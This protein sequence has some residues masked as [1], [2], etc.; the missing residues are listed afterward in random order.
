MTKKANSE[1]RTIYTPQGALTY[2]LFRKAVKNVN[3][4]IDRE[5]RVK[6]SANP[7]V[8]MSFI[9]G[10]VREKERFIREGIENVRK[11]E[12]ER[13]G[14]ESGWESGRQML[15]LGSP[16]I[17]T[18]QEGKKEGIVLKAPYLYLQ[19]KPG[20]E[21]GRREAIW[22]AWQKK[23]AGK[24][25]EERLRRMERMVAS[26]GIVCREMSIRRMT[27]RWGSCQPAKG[28]ITLNT[29]LV[30][31]PVEAIDYVVLHELAHMKYPHHQ[32]SFYDFI[33]RFMPD[34]KER[35]ELLK[36]II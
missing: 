24:I 33:D 26:Y 2:E 30:E 11:R 21:E 13:G 25:L 4:R 6:V 18:V 10:F 27:S 12:A 15:V 16:F 23:L 35:R 5:G 20:A 34:W 8:P 28:K 36:G 1:V 19:V 22:K 29:R 17:L 3:L 31:A 9:D 14:G 32:Q 7:R